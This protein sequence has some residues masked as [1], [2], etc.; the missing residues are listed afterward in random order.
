MA[1]ND[2][3]PNLCSES[4]P[5]SSLEDDLTSSRTQ[6]LLGNRERGVMV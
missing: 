6:P 5:R 3:S 2:S 1:D 4:L